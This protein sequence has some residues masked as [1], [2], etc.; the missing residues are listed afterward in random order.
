MTKS[1]QI[2]IPGWLV[3]ELDVIR[4]KND[5]VNYLYALR[6]WIKHK[7]TI[8]VK[9]VLNCIQETSG[10]KPYPS[11]YRSESGVII[12]SYKNRGQ[13]NDCI[14]DH[15]VEGAYCID[16]WNDNFGFIADDEKELSDVDEKLLIKAYLKAYKKK[17]TL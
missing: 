7:G 6:H 13:Y 14:Y 1:K 2:T 12:Q 4:K 15:F 16:S 11:K 8:R 9:K 3:D 5:D 10:I 17:K